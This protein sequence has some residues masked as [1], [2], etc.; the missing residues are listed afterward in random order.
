LDLAS[1]F[2][3][4]GVHLFWMRMADDRVAG[5]SSGQPL[6][7]DRSYVVLRLAEMYLGSSRTLWRKFSPLVHAFTSYGSDKREEHGIAG[8]GQLQ[9]LGDANLDRVIALNT[10]LAGPTPYRG[11][12][13]TVL[14]GLYS[15]P[16]EDSAAALVATVG[17]LAGI[18]GGGAVGA[19]QLAQVIKSGVDGILG[20]DGTRL[21][22]GVRDSFAI[23][24]PLRT[25]FHVAIGAPENEIPRDRLWLRDT[26]LVEGPSPVAGRGYVGQDYFVLRLDGPDRR[27]DWPGLS[28]LGDFEGRFSAVLSNTTLDD[29]T[30]RA[31]LGRIWPEFT[32][33]LR[34]SDQLTR[35]DAG[36]IANDVKTD[37]QARLR[38][39]SGGNPFETRS[40]G[41]D[42]VRARPAGMVDFAD[43]PQYGAGQPEAGERSLTS[44]AF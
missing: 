24:N 34:M 20:L 21:R 42:E 4:E 26:R 43:V 36:Q 9:E 31:E 10:R 12:D 5:G 19:A 6:E 13:V 7:A 1:L 18:V 41:T 3:T 14:M 28:A 27:S 44:V 15:V 17:A 2:R 37:L 35:Y 30:R 23:D 39:I 11:G 38:A 25:G 16:R 29:A 8:P 33:A 32:E 40:W 22:L